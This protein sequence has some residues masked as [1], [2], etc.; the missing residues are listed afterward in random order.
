MNANENE[1]LC[2]AVPI[3]EFAAIARDAVCKGK[4]LPKQAVQFRVEQMMQRYQVVKFIRQPQAD[5]PAS[6]D[7]SPVGNVEQNAQ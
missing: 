2:V 7:P 4:L 6:T 5:P 3:D 1:I